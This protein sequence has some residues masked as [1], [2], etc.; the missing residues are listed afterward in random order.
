MK[1]WVGRWIIVVSAIHTVFALAFF[2]EALSSILKRGVFNTVGNDPMT[3][4]VVWFVL[5]GAMLFVYG[6]LVD[7]IE[8]TSPGQL[9]KNIGWGL[10][11]IG[12]IGIALMP[13]SGF[14]LIFPPAIAVI[15]KKNKTR[16]S[17]TE[18]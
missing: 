1:R 13:A 15:T 12:I 7:V 18:T 8:K 2:G 10:L 3:G 9:P 4:A 5:F 11:A 17:P 14:W 16:I 6:L